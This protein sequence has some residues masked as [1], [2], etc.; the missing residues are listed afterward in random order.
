MRYNPALDG[1]RAS[2]V[3]M[4]LEYHGDWHTLGW[5]GYLGVDVFFVLSGF[6]ITSILLGQIASGGIR[7]GE[8]Y[9]RRA[10]RLYPALCVLVALPRKADADYVLGIEVDAVRRLH[11]ADVQTAEILV[12]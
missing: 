8:F 12:A 5:R 3:L 6:L 9:L 1:I 11:G 2:A 10:R 4:V 7:L